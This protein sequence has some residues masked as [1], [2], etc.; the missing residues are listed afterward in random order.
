MTDLSDDL[1]S[2]ANKT[3]IPGAKKTIAH[4]AEV[5]NHIGIDKSLIPI[6]YYPGYFW[7]IEDQQLYSIKVTGALKPLK[8]RR[9]L[10]SRESGKAV[11]QEKNVPHYTV[12]MKGKRQVLTVQRIRR[13]AG[14]ESHYGYE[15]AN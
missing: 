9:Q 3:R 10:W 8:M 14:D 13:L 15:S 1:H 11:L 12:S 4:T 7:S 6:K 5:I 2:I